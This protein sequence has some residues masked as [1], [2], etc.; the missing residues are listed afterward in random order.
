MAIATINPATG[1]TLK[2]FEPL[3]DVEIAAKLDLADQAFEKYRHTSFAERS[4]A[5]QAAANILE[6][7]KADFAKLMTLEM[8]KPY[9]A[10]IAEV[11]KCAAVCRYYAENAADFL[12]DVSVK[13]DASHSFVRYQPLGIILAVMPWNFPFW[14]VFRF[15]APA[16]MA[17]NVGLLKH[18]SNVPQCALAI[19][20]IIHRAGFPKGVFQ[21]LLIGAAKVADLIADERV[22]AAT[23]TGSEPAGASLA[24]AAGKQIKKTVLELGGS[25]PF[26]VLESADVEAAAATATS[27]RMLNNGQSCIAAKRFIVAE[28][29]AD[30]FE[31]LLLEKFTALKIGDPL[32]PDTDLGPLATPDILQDLDQQVQTAVKSGGKVLTGGYPLADRP[33]N[34]YPATIIIDIPVDQPIAQ[35]EFFGPVALLFR[36]PDIDTA[37]QLANATPFGLGASAWTNND[38]ERDRLISEIEAGAVFING[39]VK[40]DP[41]LPF[42][43]IKRSGYG[44]ELSIQGIHEFVNVKTVWVK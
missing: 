30:Q 13:T 19:E 20:D 15:A 18:A 39:L 9:K 32:H 37:I 23:L 40:S 41:R 31:K 1:E 28:A 16:L 22:K 4:Q 38:Q 24:A 21:T 14:Q 36:V 42:G 26:I 2:T 3:N 43:G 7:E 35:E 11:E 6:Q 33:G 29:I 12:A 17:G 5:L 27:A 8:G 44:R 25:D 10:A 34:F